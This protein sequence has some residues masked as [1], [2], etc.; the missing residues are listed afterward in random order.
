VLSV[1]S[2]LGPLRIREGL[3]LLTPGKKEATKRKKLLGCVG[4]AASSKN[5]PTKSWTGGKVDTEKNVT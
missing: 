1:N 3:V 4:K 2:R 5:R